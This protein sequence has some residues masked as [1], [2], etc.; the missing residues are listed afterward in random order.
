[1]TDRS[2]TAVNAD[3]ASLRSVYT[4]NLPEIL[5]GLNASLVVSTYQTGKVILYSV[6]M[7]LD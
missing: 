5:A 6:R 3:E 1:M 2:A 4:T 7:R